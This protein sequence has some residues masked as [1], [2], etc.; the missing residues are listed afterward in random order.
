MAPIA[1][2]NFFKLKTKKYCAAFSTFLVSKAMTPARLENSCTTCNLDQ[3]QR[4]PFTGN[5]SKVNNRLHGTLR[6]P[7]IIHTSKTADQVAL[8]IYV[9]NIFISPPFF[10][11]LT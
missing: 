3:I 4:N 2:T 10:I 9:L 7:P 1:K 8:T 5:Q 6:V 11:Y